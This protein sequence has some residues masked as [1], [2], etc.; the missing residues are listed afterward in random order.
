MTDGG[1]S[2]EAINKQSN[3]IHFDED[4]SLSTTENDSLSSRDLHL[5]KS[6]SS[7]HDT[8]AVLLTVDD[9][10]CLVGEVVGGYRLPIHDPHNEYYAYILIR[11]DDDFLHVTKAALEP[12]QNPIWTLS[13]GSLFFLETSARELATKQLQ[14]SVWFKR[15]DP[16][17]LTTLER[18]LVGQATV[19]CITLIMDNLNEQPIE[20]DVMPDDQGVTTTASGTLTLRFRLATI[21]D[22]DFVEAFTKESKRRAK[23]SPSDLTRLL[24]LQDHRPLATLVTETDETNVARTSFVN[25]LS[26]AFSARNIFHHGEQ[27][28]RVKPFPDKDDADKTMYLSPKQ[29]KEE[30]LKPSKEWIEAGCSGSVAKLYLEI[31]SCHDL[32]NADVGE[33]MGNLTDCFICAVFE[34]AMVQT[35]VIDDE[36]NPHWLPWTQRAFVFGCMHPASILYLGAFDFELGLSKHEPLGRVSVNISNLQRDT[37][38]VLT[39]PMYKSSHV[40]ERKAAGFI[41]IRLRIEYIDERKVLLAALCPRPK[42][43]VNVYKEK[44]LKVVRYTCFGEYGDDNNGEKF[45]LI[46]MRSYANELLEHKDTL[47][48]CIG[49]A[50]LSVIF[51]RGQVK[52]WD[53]VYIP[54]HSFVIFCS[55]AYL[56]EHPYMAPSFFLL[57]IAWI[58]LATNT[59]RRQHPSPWHRCPSFWQYAKALHHGRSSLLVQ[60]IQPDEGRAVAASYEAAWSQRMEVDRKF[61]ATRAQLIQ[62]V[63]DFGNDI[64]HTKQSDLIPLDLL[65][66][67]SYYQALLGQYC[68]YFRFVKIIATWEES[69]ISFWITAIFLVAG[70]VSLVVPWAFILRWIGRTCVWCFLG[71][72]MVIVDALLHSGNNDDDEVLA[73]LI[74]SYRKESRLVRQRRQVAVKLKDIKQTLFGNYST[75]IPSYNLSRHYD[76]PLSKSY[77]KLSRGGQTP[78]KL[79]DMYIP[80]Q[81]CFGVMIPRPHMAA[82]Q[83]ENEKLALLKTLDIIQRHVKAITSEEDQQFLR[84]VHHVIEDEGRGEKSTSFSLELILT[85]TLGL[86]ES[87]HGKKVITKSE[88]VMVVSEGM[89]M[90][91]R[92]TLNHG[93]HRELM[94]TACEEKLDGP[95]ELLSDDDPPR[96]LDAF[97]SA[98]DIDECQ[99]RCCALAQDDLDGPHEAVEVMLSCASTSDD[100]EEDDKTEQRCKATIYFRPDTSKRNV[101]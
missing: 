100:D 82:A 96:F 7:I 9:P 54:L 11:Y 45:D 66:K 78:I 46:V 29:I 27:K 53:N 22:Q 95:L 60:S 67:L 3:D 88:R 23:S 10:I 34:D 64:I 6:Q 40:T 89:R 71:P 21:S 69:I 75:L 17:R 97:N 91:R 50:M 28:V 47:L 1:R 52:V 87:E 57:S 24:L 4:V 86:K 18:L 39:Y 58:M 5:H 25:A 76:R 72:H 43:H 49:D 16:L 26:N 13:S 8:D 55:T 12:G 37:D 48:Y 41:R 33:A 2:D 35:P 32:P 85:P 81:Q 38:Y 36:L 14:L 84:Q 93:A 15:K 42:F 63:S 61:A 44:S 70:I 77:A 68:K 65:E 51:W 92:S 83:H 73:K 101:H 19:D 30:T 59:V 31:L 98:Y 90:N 94:A 62:E 80:G 74:D 99:E 56:V 79:A 20:V